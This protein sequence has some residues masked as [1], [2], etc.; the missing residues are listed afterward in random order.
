MVPQK[1]REI[2]MGLS[3]VC[4]IRRCNVCGEKWEDTGD[5]KCPHCGSENTEIVMKD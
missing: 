5:Y 1:W 2:K 4:E 3:E